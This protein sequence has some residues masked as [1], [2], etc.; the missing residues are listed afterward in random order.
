M[1]IR[2]INLY[3]KYLIFFSFLFILFLGLISVKDYGHSSDE[4]AQ[5]HAGFV[6]L[7]YIGEKIAPSLHS[8]YKG[9]RVYIDLYDNSYNEKF[10]GHSL[11]TLSALLEVIFEIEDRR[12]VFI[13]KHHIYFI[14]FF[15]SLIS[16]YKI[17]QIRFEKWYISIIGVFIIFLSPRIF[18]NSFY[19][20]KDIPFLS[21]LI[22]SI[23][24]GL[25]LFKKMNFKN[26]IYYS[27]FNAFV[28]SGIRVYGIISPVL[29]L[30]SIILY[31]FITKEN[32]KKNL[33][34]VI[35]CLILTFVF[36]IIIKPSLWESPIANFIGSFTYLKEF[37]KIWSIPNLFL[38]EIILSKDTPWF[39]SIFWI[40]ITTPIFYTVLFLF[41]ISFYL[42]N[43]LTNLRSIFL[44]KIFYYDSI[45]FSLLVIPIIGS[46]ILRESS[47]NSWRHLYFIYPY[48]VIFCL[49][50]FENILNFI[51][52]DNFKN[53][54]YVFFLIILL[55]N[56]SWIIKNHPYQYSYFNLLAGKDNLNN[57]FD[58]DY[59]GLSYKQN[60]EFIIDNDDR[61]KIS[62]VNNSINKPQLF[63]YSLNKID[64]KRFVFNQNIAKPDYIITNYFLDNIEKYKKISADVI[65]NEYVLFN[66]IIVDGNTINTIYKKK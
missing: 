42:I 22:F 24:F 16:F 57:K 50:G 6:E 66:E 51:K 4:S 17:C 8:R 38:G 21:I 33:L 64:R 32:F 25:I 60:L 36:S 31:S 26:L 43:S 49:I 5:R 19:D 53:Y 18:A 54:F 34:F 61:D 3:K 48:F 30:S 39:F 65:E 44:N 41:G 55:F 63:K 7:N 2:Y 28:I 12:D 56:L 13:L 59:H 62:V 40:S 10:S 47:F 45:F 35:Y 15:L 23:H 46:I 9:D 14:I 1:L 52:K 27:L 58:I 11:N 37:G 20:P 29:I